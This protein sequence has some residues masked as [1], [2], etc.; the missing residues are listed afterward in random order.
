MKANRFMLS[1]LGGLALMTSGCY[2]ISVRLQPEDTS[3]EEVLLGSDCVMIILGIGIGTATIEQAKAN[4]HP[5]GDPDPFPFGPSEGR[6]IT[7]VRRVEY[8]ERY[9]FLS[10]DRCVDVTGE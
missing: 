1:M 9:F 2:D 4:A 7:K 5:I 8:T 3:V 10:G 6:R